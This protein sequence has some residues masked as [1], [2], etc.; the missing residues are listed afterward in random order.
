VI[1]RPP[2]APALNSP[3]SVGGQPGSL[4]LHA[5][6]LSELDWAEEA[7]GLLDEKRL[8]AGPERAVPGPL[9][10]ARSSKR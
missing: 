10:Y 5:R 6:I 1:R 2:L 7:Q 3:P 9:V 8:E 4:R